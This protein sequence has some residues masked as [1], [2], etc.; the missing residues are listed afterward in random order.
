MP[1]GKGGGHPTAPPTVRG[2]SDDVL[3]YDSGL[4]LLSLLR[5]V[6]HLDSATKAQYVHPIIQARVRH[7]CAQ[8]RAKGLGSARG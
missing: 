6:D 2:K 7:G 5:V 8:G 4:I 3:F 1:L